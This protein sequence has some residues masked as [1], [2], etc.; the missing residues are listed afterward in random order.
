M[1]LMKVLRIFVFTVFLGATIL[2]LAFC[3]E[4]DDPVVIGSETVSETVI[5]AEWSFIS[6][7]KD[8]K[9]FPSE[10]HIIERRN[11]LE[12]DME[13]GIIPVCSICCRGRK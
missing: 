5:G 9:V 4:N 1:R 6:L 12:I 2:P 7:E 8:Q 13:A 10:D 11:T 3:N